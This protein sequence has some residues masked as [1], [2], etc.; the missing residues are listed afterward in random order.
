M[1]KKKLSPIKLPA[2]YDLPRDKASLNYLFGKLEKEL[3]SE[4]IQVAKELFEMHRTST[5]FDPLTLSKA[6]IK[7]FRANDLRLFLVEINDILAKVMK[8]AEYENLQVSVNYQ[9]VFSQ[10][11]KIHL[12]LDSGLI[13]EAEIEIE[14]L[15]AELGKANEIE[16]LLA[17]N[18][19]CQHFYKLK[20]LT[21]KLDNTVKEYRLLVQRLE[22]HL[23]VAF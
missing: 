5:G 12:Q 3:D 11:Q 7:R 15:K 9:L 2:L 23:N 18:K 13:E 6:R 17:L 22:K 10:F 20:E 8:K 4:K 16:L 19:I 21:D 1:N 14:N